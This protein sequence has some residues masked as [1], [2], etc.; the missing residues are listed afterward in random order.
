MNAVGDAIGD[1][2]DEHKHAGEAKAYEARRE[3]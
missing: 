3:A 1:A 2:V